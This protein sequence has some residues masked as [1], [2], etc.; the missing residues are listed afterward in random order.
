MSESGLSKKT[1]NME[2]GALGKQN[3]DDVGMGISN[4]TKLRGKNK[5]VGWDGKKE[6]LQN[7]Y[8]LLLI[9]LPKENPQELLLL[10]HL[11]KSFFPI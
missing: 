1:K 10:F 11:L 9:A 7:Q 2:E 3:E 8:P 5:R 4:K 6:Y